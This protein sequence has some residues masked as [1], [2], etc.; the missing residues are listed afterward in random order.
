MDRCSESLREAERA[1]EV[2]DPDEGNLALLKAESIVRGVEAVA[3]NHPMLEL[4]RAAIAAQAPRLIPRPL[5][6]LR[7]LGQS[8]DE[9]PTC[10]AALAERP[11]RKAKCPHCGAF[12]FCRTRPID[13]AQVLLKESE[14]AALEED[15]VTDYKMPP[16]RSLRSE[17]TQQC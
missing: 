2:A 8:G 17:F 9:C 5:P 13:G 1:L 7:A 11:Q 3:P 6:P 16:S 4:A 14:L 15:W 12:V 10:R